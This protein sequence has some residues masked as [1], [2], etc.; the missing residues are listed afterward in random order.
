[1]AF[2]L[3][4]GLAT[5]AF[6]AACVRRFGPQALFG[7]LPLGLILTPGAMLYLRLD[8]VAT[9]GPLVG[10]QVAFVYGA[11]AMLAWSAG[12]VLAPRMRGPA[13]VALVTVPGAVWGA[14]TFLALPWLVVSSALDPFVTLPA[15]GWVFFGIALANVPQSFKTRREVVRIVLGDEDAGPEPVRVPVSAREP[16]RQLPGR[17]AE[18]PLRIVQITDPHLGAFRS[19][20]SLRRICERAVAAEPDLVLLTGDFYTREGASHPDALA[21]ALAP[22]AALRGRTF[23]C[24][25][26]HDHESPEAVVEA[27]DA[28]GAR[29]LVDEAELVPTPHGRVQ[30]IGL[31]HRWVGRARPPRA[32]LRGDPQD[33]SGH[34]RVLATIPRVEGALRLVMLHDPSAFRT[35]PAGSADLV[36]SG[37][38]HGGHIG[39]VSLGLPWTI[40]G[41]LTSIPDHGLWG[42]GRERLYVHRGTG[43][44]GFPLRIG[45]PAEESVLEVVRA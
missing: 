26:N 32:Q 42:R 27:L 14:G 40:I 3:C 2:V 33:A 24:L 13:W 22:L 11:L 23:A 30:L 5:V 43:H 44:Y 34:A 20:E 39:L 36:L 35:L 31:D 19:E 1:M 25:G 29:L 37:H 8:D 10:L 45:V 38:T 28:V 12:M 17:P 16:V 18:G 41:A 21:R 4:A 7:L 9:G 15:L 6:L